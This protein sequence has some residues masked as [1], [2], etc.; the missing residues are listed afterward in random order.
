[1]IVPTWFIDKEEIVTA[2]VKRDVHRSDK[3]DAQP[4]AQ[5]KVAKVMCQCQGQRQRRVAK[6]V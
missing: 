4:V 6:V 2:R 1:M 3:S 5:E